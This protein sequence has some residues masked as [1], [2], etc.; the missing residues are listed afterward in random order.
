M[1]GQS[2]QICESNLSR[3]VSS[4][5]EP[6]PPPPSR[7]KSRAVCLILFCLLVMAW[8]ALPA[9]A[10][11]PP[12]LTFR[13]Y[14]AAA[15]NR[16]ATTS[17][18]D[19]E[20]W[21]DRALL[22]VEG[23]SG[24]LGNPANDPAAF[25]VLRHIRPIHYMV[26]QN[27]SWRGVANPTGAFAN[28]HGSRVH[29][30]LHVKGNGTVRFKVGDVSWQWWNSQQTYTAKRTLSSSPPTG[31]TSSPN[32]VDCNYGWAY[33]WGSDRAKGGGDDTKICN[34]ESTLVDELFFVGAGLALTSDRR[35]NDPDRYPDFVGQ[36]L[37]EVLHWYCSALN[38]AADVRENGL[39]F[40]VTASDGSQYTHLA[41]RSNDEFGQRLNPANCR[42]TQPDPDPE[43]EPAPAA[44]R[45]PKTPVHTGEILL[46]QGYRLSATHG[47][48]S[49]V[50]FQ[51]VDA[52]GVGN[53]AALAA[54]LLDAIDVWAYVE[55][56]VTVCFPLKQE[57]AGFLFLDAA[58]SPR[59]LTPLQSYI[60]E[61]Q[62]CAT[63]YRP[64]TIVLVRQ[65]APTPVPASNA[66]QLSNCM[67]T[68][69]AILNFRDGPAGNVLSAVPYNVA[70]TAL[71]RTEDWFKVDNH[72]VKGWIS[73]D[74]VTTSGSCQ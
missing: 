9:S 53:Q 46:E 6:L 55:Q 34:Q 64:G 54:G 41:K 63:I 68:T 62:I 10:Q 8:G 36:T 29:F 16:H 15:P 69:T 30:V 57:G 24:D 27:K 3:N 45:I 67:V 28:Q 71:K 19:Y 17:L 32:K 51:R 1:A 37:Q 50:Q 35:F 49:G 61:G 22:F 21:V 40:E 2:L 7:I 38:G 72:G 26:T 66:Q 18:S 4:F 44:T 73:A 42:P 12:F 58:T 65:G 52:V 70:L 56:G 47:L 20:T 14:P 39:L 25:S 31:Y 48:R 11:T 23:R 74:Y 43:P 33:D 59:T 5:P 60:E 13:V